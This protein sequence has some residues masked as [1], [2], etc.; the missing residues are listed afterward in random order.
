MCYLGNSDNPFGGKIYYLAELVWVYLRGPP[1]YI[2]DIDACESESDELES[3]DRHL[4]HRLNFSFLFP[5]IHIFLLSKDLLVLPMVRK[6]FSKSRKAESQAERMKAH[7]RGN[8]GL[9]H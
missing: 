6:T 9:P 7:P 5:T 3:G 1:S 2:I 4:S 8:M